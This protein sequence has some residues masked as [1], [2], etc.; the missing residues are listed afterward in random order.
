MWIELQNVW[1]KVTNA[2]QHELDWL[3]N[4]L[5]MPGRFRPG[6]SRTITSVFNAYLSEFPSGL[7]PIVQEGARDAGVVVEVR[8]Q[9]VNPLTMKPHPLSWLRDYQIDVV[10]E[11]LVAQ[12]GI[13]DSPTGSGKTDIIV[14]LVTVLPTDWLILVPRV[15]LLQQTRDRFMERTGV[16]VGVWGDGMYDPQAVTVGVFD[17]IYHGLRVQDGRT[18]KRL[19]RFKGVIVDEVH[20]VA[21]Q[22]TLLVMQKLPNAYY[23]I[24]FSGTPLMR[25]DE[26]GLLTIGATG[27][28]FTKIETAALIEGGWL[29][30]PL[31]HAVSRP[32]ETRETPFGSWAT[33]ELSMIGSKNRIDFVTRQV[34]LADKP[35]L[36]FVRVI[37]HGEKIKAALLARGI[38]ADFVH[39]EETTATRTKLKNALMAGELEALVASVVFQVGVDMPALRSVVWAAGGKAAIAGLQ[40]LG[41]GMRRVEGKDT[42]DFYDIADTMCPVCCAAGEPLHR[43]CKWFEEHRKQRFKTYRKAGH[44]ISFT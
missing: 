31:I 16:K 3:F 4:F 23:R 38:K 7:V 33:A 10:L 18:E 41:R 15:D 30:K 42:F 5:T 20:C 22:K 34:S 40:A 37:K 11:C 27:G 9:R 19:Q 2:T 32:I 28:V 36:V 8:D 35:T 29:A 43:A 26:K 39:G 21:G 17:S 25:S 1:A 44:E 14:G 24:G 13:V 6:K 12:Q